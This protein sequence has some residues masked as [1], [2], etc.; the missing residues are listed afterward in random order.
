MKPAVRVKN[1]LRTRA[2]PWIQ[3]TC[4]ENLEILEHWISTE[5]CESWPDSQ[6][7]RTTWIPLR[8]TSQPR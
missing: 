4:R 5:I 8:R 1:F 3:L 2:Q 6:K 7:E